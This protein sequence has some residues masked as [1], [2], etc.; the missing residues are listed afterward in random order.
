MNMVFNRPN[1]KKLIEASHNNSGMNLIRLNWLLD[2]RETFFGCVHKK[3][4]RKTVYIIMRDEN[5]YR[6]FCD[7]GKRIYIYLIVIE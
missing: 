1:T 6:L 7:D 2:N 3:W 4:F 5:E